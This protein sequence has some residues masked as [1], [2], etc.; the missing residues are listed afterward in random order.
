[1]LHEHTSEVSRENEG[2]DDNEAPSGVHLRLRESDTNTASNE[3]KSRR[4][5]PEVFRGEENHGGV[6]LVHRWEEVKQTSHRRI[7]GE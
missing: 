5:Q 1:M 3:R 2:K 6:E 4:V 7:N